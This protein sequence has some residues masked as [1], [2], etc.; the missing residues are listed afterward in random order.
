MHLKSVLILY[1]GNGRGHVGDGVIMGDAS[2]ATLYAEKRR[3][4]NCENQRRCRARRE[5]IV[6]AS[7]T[8]DIQVLQQAEV[9]RPR[10]RSSYDRQT[11]R[12][13]AETRNLL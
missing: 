8:T 3:R 12:I 2:C 11:Q 7:A 9:A 5:T 13:S 4:D 10:T 1:G 6:A